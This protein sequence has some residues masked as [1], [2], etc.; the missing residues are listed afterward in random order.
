MIANTNKAVENGKD[1]NKVEETHMAVG[2][3]MGTIMDVTVSLIMVVKEAEAV[4]FLFKPQHSTK[5][6]CN[7]CGMS[8]H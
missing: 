5:S 7:R 2:D 8:N 6:V 1:V 4:V 3:G